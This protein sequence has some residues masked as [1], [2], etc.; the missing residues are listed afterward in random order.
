MNR[1]QIFLRDLSGVN[2]FIPIGYFLEIVH[3][4]LQH[5]YI[6]VA[7]PKAAC[8]TIKAT[9]IRMELDDK[10]LKFADSEVVH[11]R[12]L[13]PHLNPKQIGSFKE[14]IADPSFFKFCFV[15]NP[16]DRVLSCYLD[17]IEGN[18]AQ[19]GPLM[20][21]LGRDLF[22]NETIT[23][24]E[25]IE[26]VGAQPISLMNGHWR[27]QYYQTM[28]DTIPYDF[29]GKVESFAEDMATVSEA[30]GH[31]V[32]EFY[33]GQR[34]K[35]TDSVSKRQDYYDEDLKEL[36]YRTYKIDFDHFGYDR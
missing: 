25:F 16:Y 1:W 32:L 22:K 13:S 36:V 8:S 27:M 19:K 2:Q 21:Q 9:L 29:V 34:L 23:F 3:I 26:L 14:I 30:V 28:Q 33:D 4:S 5:K 31:D 11:D 7:T 12:R 10:T 24:R 18:A 6:Y 15:R 20:T 17:K 35:Q